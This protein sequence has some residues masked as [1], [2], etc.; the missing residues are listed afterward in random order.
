MMRARLVVM[1]LVCTQ[2]VSSYVGGRVTDCRDSSALEGADVQLTTQA[3]DVAWT[4]QQT[5]SDGVYAFKV[6]SK[7][8]L[9]VT[10][11][12]AKK[13]Y[14]TTQKTYSSVPDGPQ[15]LCMQPTMR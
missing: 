12:A 13:G 15:D 10:L 4:A 11:T 14:R 6:D 2:C 8:V 9:P 1:T 7:Q 5:G 3:A